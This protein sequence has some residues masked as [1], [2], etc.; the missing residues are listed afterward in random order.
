MALERVSS[1]R[2]GRVKFRKWTL[3]HSGE[4]LEKEESTARIRKGD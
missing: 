2:L 3:D 1:E 4:I